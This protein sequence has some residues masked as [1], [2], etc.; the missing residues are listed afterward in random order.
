MTRDLGALRGHTVDLGPRGSESEGMAQMALE[1]AQLAGPAADNPL[2][3]TNIETDELR[4]RF[5]A[6]D[7]A[8]LPD[9]IFE[10]AI[11]PSQLALPFLRS[12]GYRLVPLPFA[13]AMRLNALST[14]VVGAEHEVDWQYITDVTIPAFTYSMRP[15]APSAPLPTVGSRVLLIANERVPNATIALVLEAVF[16]SRFARIADPPL[17]PSVLDLPARLRLHPGTI[18]YRQRDDPLLTADSVNTM[19]NALGVAGALVGATIF[20]LQWRRQRTTSRR[21]ELFGAYVQRAADIERRLAALELS[22]TLD[23][24]TLIGLQREVLEVK[25]EALE[26]FAAGELGSQTALYE[27]LAPLNTTRDQI[28]NLLLH[29]RENLAERAAE[30]GRSEQ[31]IWRDAA[32]GTPEPTDES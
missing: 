27:L 19:N 21:D 7:R 1:F 23:L 31:A 24:P 26:R 15:P 32:K 13:D 6:Q 22:A 11:V 28:G 4:K 12:G 17:D 16:R 10:L 25:T 20:L 18:A 14:H 3:T 8:A 2:A 9:A 29:V 5:R 30:E